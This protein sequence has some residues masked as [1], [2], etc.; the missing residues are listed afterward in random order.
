MLSAKK[1]AE[2]LDICVVLLC[3]LR[4]VPP[5]VLKG[6]KPQ[7]DD[8]WGDSSIRNTPHVVL[9]VVRE[10][11]THNMDVAFERKANVYVLK[12]RNDRTGKVP[13]E[14]D[15]ERVRFLEAPSTEE[16][17]VEESAR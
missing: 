9:W 1:L 12:S 8:I 3:Q 2:R 15:P 14:F 13:L 11:F 17:S 10:F 4:K 6:A 7:L 5:K 16:D